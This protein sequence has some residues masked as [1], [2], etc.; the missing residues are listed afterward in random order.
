MRK[1]A[2][3][4]FAMAFCCAGLA[5]SVVKPEVI[6]NPVY[7]A[8]V[9]LVDIGHG[10]R[11]NL[12]CIG[13]G[14]PVVIFD[15]GMGDSTI[16]WA[17]VQAAVSKKTMA[18]SFDRAGL[19]FSDAARHA[20]TPRNQ[21]E[22]LHALL[23]AAHI[24]PPYVLVGH[25]MAGM[26]V[27]VYTDKYPDEVAGMVLVDGS[28]ED[29]FAL[30]HAIGKTPAKEREA[31]W[32][33]HLRD[34][35]ACI[36]DAEKGLV[37]GAPAF[38]KCVGDVSDPSFSAAINAVQEKYMVTPRW[39][40]AVASERENLEYESAD[41]TRATRKDFGDIPLIVLTSSPRPKA[42]DETREEQDMREQWTLAWE[43]LH[44]EVASMSTRGI[45][46]IV[47]NSSHYIQYDH[48]QVVV[49]AVLQA[50]TIAREQ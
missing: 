24:K 26:N 46:I 30:G 25:S 35:H 3:A 22:D 34:M 15:A 20:S 17:L 31:Q 29:Q 10:Q 23:Q 45:N 14:S 4:A 13:S 19:G 37:R 33:A 32:D 2:T 38:K 7:T 43:G 21:S 47:P 11:M 9:K 41:E 40:A 5:E 39:Q 8:P 18:C 50:V 48:P 28:H 42:K 16:S 44:T 6:T 1:T 36:A 49:D 27:R 12:Y